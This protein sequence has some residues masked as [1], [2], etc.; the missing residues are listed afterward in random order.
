MLSAVPPMRSALH[1][2]ENPYATAR[3]TGEPAWMDISDGRLWTDEVTRLRARSVVAVPFGLSTH[4]LGVLM[5]Y[6]T[7]A[8]IPSAKREALEF[9]ASR[10]AEDVEGHRDPSAA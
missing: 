1:D 3:L 10:I 2:P 8:V 9:F 5:I 7:E 6:W 4:R